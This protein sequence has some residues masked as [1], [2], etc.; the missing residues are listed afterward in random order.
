MMFVSE[1]AVNA[2]A[3]DLIQDFE[4]GPLHSRS[5]VREILPHAIEVMA[6]HGMPFRRSLAIVIAKRAQAAWIEMIHA[7]K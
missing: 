6:E 4:I 3:D 5:S 2:A 7:I 1:N